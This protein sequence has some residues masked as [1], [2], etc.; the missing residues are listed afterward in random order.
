M[1]AN[2]TVSKTAHADSRDQKMLPLAATELT[3][4]STRVLIRMNPNDLHSLHQSFSI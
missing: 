1:H 2:A 3:T 4:A